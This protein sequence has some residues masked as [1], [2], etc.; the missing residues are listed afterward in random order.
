M[1]ESG[2]HV[3]ARSGSAAG[4]PSRDQGDP[5]L[6]VSKARLGKTV[7]RKWRLDALLGVGGMAAV[8]AATHRN[9]SRVAIKMLHPLVATEEAKRRFL[10]EGYLANSV[11][12]PG[13]VRVLDDDE[14]E[15]GAIFLV[16]ELLDGESLESFA[17]RRVQLGAPETLAVAEQV[18]E[19]LAV[20]HAKGIVHRDVKPENVFLCVDGR[21]KLLDFGIARLL[22]VSRGSAATHHGFLLGTP[23]Y[24]APEQARG[25][26]ELVDARTDVWAAGASMFR[27]LTGHTVHRGSTH[28]E[29]LMKATREPA[30]KV[31]D[32]APAVPELVASLVD[33]ALAFRKEDRWASADEMLESLREVHRA[34]RYTDAPKLRARIAATSTV[35]IELPAPPAV[36]AE[37]DRASALESDPIGD[38]DDDA[39][40]QIEAMSLTHREQLR[41]IVIEV[42]MEPDAA[43]PVLPSIFDET[44]ETRAGGTPLAPP[45]PRAKPEPPPRTMPLTRGV[46]AWWIVAA[47][48][49]L[50]FAITLAT[51]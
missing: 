17:T 51:R 9:G 43:T 4:E 47:L 36:S 34:L 2:T 27:V 37:F 6:R 3:R 5:Y 49:V 46:I 1:S 20:A 7:R 23:A 13:V 26:W 24:M 48:A 22:E 39:P 12:H 50:V 29:L 28:L 30:P 18:L 10:R 21:V 15:D 40:T 42:P 31:R 45:T 25:D 38:T 33:R 19:V 32:V 44:G 11:G 8:Y 35:R 16:M 14:A 41:S